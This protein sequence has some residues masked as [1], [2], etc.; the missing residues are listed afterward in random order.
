MESKEKTRSKRRGVQIRYIRRRRQ[1]EG[2]KEKQGKN[3]LG[4]K[5]I[6]IRQRP[7]AD[8]CIYVFYSIIL[9]YIIFIISL[10]FILFY[11]TL[12][13]IILYYI[14]YFT[15]FYFILFYTIFLNYN[16]FSLTL[17]H[18]FLG[19]QRRLGRGAESHGAIEKKKR[20]GPV[21]KKISKHKD[22]PI[23]LEGAGVQSAG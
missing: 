7:G 4:K 18:N 17:T 10:H 16:H 8:S 5:F 21:K 23:K 15:S 12:Y 19:M 20:L 11:I 3:Y 1:T 14:Y 2:Q 9:Y 13:Y 22:C 6:R